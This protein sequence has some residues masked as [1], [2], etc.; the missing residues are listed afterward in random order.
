MKPCPMNILP[1]YEMNIKWSFADTAMKRMKKL[2]LHLSMLARNFIATFF[3]AGCGLK[4]QLSMCAYLFHRKK[5]ELPEKLFF[6]FLIISITIANKFLLPFWVSCI[7][8]V[9]LDFVMAFKHQKE[10]EKFEV[11]TLTI[12]WEVWRVYHGSWLCALVTS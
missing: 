4:S 6:F 8:N 10:N 12:W 2:S 1:F 5:F 3:C 11:V 9:W 7:L